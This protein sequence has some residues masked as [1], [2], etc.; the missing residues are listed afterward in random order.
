M[1]IPEAETLLEDLRARGVSPRV[2]AAI[3]AVPRDRFVP[4]GLRARAWEDGPLPIGGGQTISQPRVVALMCDALALTGDERVLDVGTGSGWHAALLAR[5]AA[6]V[7]TVERDPAIARQ[8]AAN[9]SAAGASNVTTVVGDGV[10]ALEDEAAFAAINVAA[11]GGERDLAE[12][13][14]RLAD[15]GRLVAPVRAGRHQRLIVAERRGDDLRRRD[16]GRVSFVPLR[17]APPG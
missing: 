6:H 9:L 3:A 16:L 12:L 13:T 5:L 10:P 17:R 1:V 4:P 2:L 8:G 14:A 11:A 7:W 15:G